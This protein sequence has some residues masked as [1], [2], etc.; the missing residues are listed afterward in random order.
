MNVQ[1]ETM[2]P[3]ESRS[4]TWCVGTSSSTGPPDVEIVTN[5]SA[6]LKPE[7]VTIT[8]TVLSSVFGESVTIGPPVTTKVAVAK[9]PAHR[10]RYR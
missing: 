10:Y 7:P 9:L 1:P 2:F 5:V 6:R 3:A 8:V 4:H